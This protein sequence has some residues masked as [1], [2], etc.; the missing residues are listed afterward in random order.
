MIRLRSEKQPENTSVRIQVIAAI[1]LLS[2]ACGKSP[3]APGNIAPLKTNITQISLVHHVDW[4]EEDLNVL[5]GAYHELQP[6]VVVKQTIFPTQGLEYLLRTRL[7]TNSAPE[8][9]GCQP[10]KDTL[11]GSAGYLLD[12]ETVLDR[13][14][15][16]VDPSKPW[17]D[18]FP[19]QAL[20][21]VRQQ[22]GRIF[23]LPYDRADYG[24]LYNAS[25][26][27]RLGLDIPETWGEWMATCGRLRAEGYVPIAWSGEYS[28]AAVNI[29][30]AFIDASF[31]EL[32]P[33][34]NYKT[35]NPDV[36]YGL[37][38]QFGD[39]GERIDPD[40]LYRAY[41]TGIFDPKGERMQFVFNKFAELSQHFQDHWVTA[42]GYEQ[43]D[44]FLHGKAACFVQGTYAVD[45]I[46]DKIRKEFKPE[47]QWEVSI[48]PIPHFAE[49]NPD[50][51]LGVT[52]TVGGFGD[53]LV[54]SVP[55]SLKGE[56]LD[57]TLD[58]LHYMFAPENYRAVYEGSPKVGAPL[59]EDIPCDPGF[60]RFWDRA[61]AILGLVPTERQ[62]QDE[63]YLHFQAYFLGRL[64][65]EELADRL[66]HVYEEW[67]TRLVRK[68]QV[69]PRLVEAFEG[70]VS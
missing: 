27:E 47:E 16:Y 62:L 29:A 41:K 45:P 12:F 30:R 7:L 54:C 63:W 46:R 64:T 67:L 66:D 10:P 36:R 33:E 5:F 13:P 61:P 44:M 1:M 28:A 58:V 53:G 56:R 50:F 39:L 14:N 3:E 18:V 40:E 42:D 35:T 37:E 43:A 32:E 19:R 20:E 31:R 15:P 25:L 11:F 24:F 68:R 23:C 59:Y 22:D 38:D 69:D 49:E 21:M 65:W 26:F 60:K 51:R 34:I 9:M 8:I 17:R 6:T 4:Y 48:L 2:S 70:G 52:R 57:I 55:S